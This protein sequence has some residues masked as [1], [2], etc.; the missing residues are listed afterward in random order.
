MVD[1]AHGIAGW[2]RGQT[3]QMRKRDAWL[4]SALGLQHRVCRVF[5]AQEH[6]AEVNCVHLCLRGV[7]HVLICTEE[8][9]GPV[10][11]PLHGV[12]LLDK[13]PDQVTFLVP[14]SPNLHRCTVR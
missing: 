11:A 1:R 2:G 9:P 13:S 12:I 3:A 7:H 4:H 5:A 8:Q 6:T 14:P 10:E